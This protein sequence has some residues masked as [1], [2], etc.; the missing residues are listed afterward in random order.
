MREQAWPTPRSVDEMH[1][2]L[3]ALGFVTAAEADAN[4]SWNG[5]LM[6]LARDQRATR[7][8]GEAGGLWTCAER[9]PQLRA[10]FP[11]APL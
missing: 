1:E 10:V 6:A 11:D 8:G 4:A 7:V 9:L 2:A 3:Q 5:W